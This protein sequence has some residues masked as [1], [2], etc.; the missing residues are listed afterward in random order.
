MN[1]D[2]GCFA[3]LGAL[4]VAFLAGSTF[5]GCIADIPYKN[6][7]LKRGYAVYH[8]ETG[9]FTWKEDLKNEH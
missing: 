6:E 4:V 9:Q 5:G 7:A 2:D 8:P 3:I 1:N